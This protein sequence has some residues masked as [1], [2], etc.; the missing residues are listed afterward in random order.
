MFGFG[1]VLHFGWYCQVFT[2][3]S[4]VPGND[5]GPAS[6]RD[7]HVPAPLEM[8]FIRDWRMERSLSPHFKEPPPLWQLVVTPWMTWK[9]YSQQFPAFW[10]SQKPGHRTSHVACLEECHKPWATATSGLSTS[11]LAAFMSSY[12]LWRDTICFKILHKNHKFHYPCLQ[13]TLIKEK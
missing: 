10:S 8:A 5:L 9:S 2:R 13:F 6:P 12:F 11:H 7:R 3:T 1:P 4:P